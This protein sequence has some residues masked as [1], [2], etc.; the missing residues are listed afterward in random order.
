[1]IRKATEEDIPV[2]KQ[3]MQ[4]EPDYWNQD[5]RPD[6]LKI[7]LGSAKDLAFVWEEDGR[8]L[9]FICAHDLGFR[10]YLSELIVHRSARRRGI[11]K[12]LV[13]RVQDELLQRKCPILFSDVWRTAEM[14]YRSL[15]WSEPNVILL[16]KK[17]DGENS[18]PPAI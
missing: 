10:A 3:L 1:M 13:Q 7:A 17:L 2:I 6:V 15:G 14:F 4:S 11:G 8:I 12:Q 5:N 16:R 9:G 18:Q